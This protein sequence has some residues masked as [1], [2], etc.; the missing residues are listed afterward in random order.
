MGRAIA[1]GLIIGLLMGFIDS[2][3]YAV[4]GY[5]TAE[6]SLIV[7]PFLVISIFK[8]LRMRLN[9]VDIIKAT[10]LAYGICITTTLTS[11]M[12]I[13]YG[14][15]SHVSERLKVY[16]LRI[17]VP[18]YIFSGSFPDYLALP[19]YVSLALISF[20]GT[21]IAFA[22][23][24]HFIEKE[25]L[26]Y[27]IG[28]ASAILTKFF[29]RTHISFKLAIVAIFFGFVL[30]FISMKIN[31]SLDLTPILSTLVPG[32]VLSLSFYPIVVGLLFLIPL[33]PLKIIS[34]GSTTTYLIVIP[35]A[36]AIFGIKVTPATSFEDALYSYSPIVV[37]SIIGVVLI[38]TLF[39]LLVYGKIFYTS[40]AMLIKL[41]MERTAFILGIS[42]ISMLGYITLIL[43]NNIGTLSILTIHIILVIL[44][45]IVLTLVN[46]RVVGE[47][48]TGSQALLP[49]ITLYMYM[50]GI[51]NLST[52]AV[53]DPFT[54]IPM[55]QVV[56]GASMNLQ[57]FARFFR[58]NIVKLVM[59][60]G[61]GMLIG[62]FT[63]YLYGNI[64]A[65]VYGFNSQYMPLTRWIPTIVWM[66]SV[67]SG[68][69]GITPTATV[70]LGAII[71][72]I[73]VVIWIRRK[74]PLFPFVVGMTM[75]PDIGILS[76]LVFIVKRMLVKLG[77]EVHEKMI[78]SSIFFLI[79]C[80]LAVLFN[81]ILI[82]LQIV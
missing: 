34:I 43:S 57:R 2:Y 22:F 50:I 65:Y 4:S 62:S 7:I 17:S 26:K 20:G 30:Q 39:Y 28:F 24:G 10:A 76:F 59:Y 66:A 72:I 55:P 61:I 41:K 80:G 48:G 25:R 23:R 1:I 71:G 56:G 45:H 69:L 42:M 54:G 64:L 40:L 13:T 33:D 16:G 67:Y 49:M 73:L 51:R 46:L 15:L 9:D 36:I 37:G 58:F 31:L 60:F 5:T 77:V 82:L 79:G 6:I 53:L 12:Y 14:F 74:M 78:I 68:R 18:Q 47:T 27:P 19:I 11:G 21:L 52:Y 8:F 38:L 75:P 70:I 29:S 35:I 44:L 63:T 32:I 3:S 81:T